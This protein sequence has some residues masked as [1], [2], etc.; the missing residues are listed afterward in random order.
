MFVAPYSSVIVYILTIN[1]EV[2]RILSRNFEIVSRVL[3][4]FVIW[5][6]LI[7]IVFFNNLYPFYFYIPKLKFLFRLGMTVKIDNNLNVNKFTGRDAFK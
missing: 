2:I 1:G 4:S 7:I 5:K 3:Q 6:L